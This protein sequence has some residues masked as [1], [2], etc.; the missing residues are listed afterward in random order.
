MF[1]FV[2]YCLLGYEV[3]LLYIIGCDISHSTYVHMLMTSSEGYIKPPLF[4][5]SSKGDCNVSSTSPTQ[6]L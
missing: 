1:I 3:S 6:Q 4:F 5:G 2:C